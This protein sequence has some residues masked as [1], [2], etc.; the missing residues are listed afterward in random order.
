MA[1]VPAEKR[2][3]QIVE[4][5]ARVIARAGLESATTRV[6]AAEAGVPQG[7]LHYAFRDKT[8]LLAAVFQYLGER[9]AAMLAAC[10]TDGCGLEVGVRTL[11]A[12]CIEAWIRDEEMLVANYQVYFWCISPPNSTDL[13]A[14]AYVAYKAVIAEALQRAAGGALP[15]ERAAGLAQFLLNAMDGILIQ[16]LADRDATTARSSA[17]A[18]AEAALQRYG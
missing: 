15:E 7:T 17:Q 3:R 10:V 8:E 9:D 16:Y 6:I 1:Y 2:R 14:R 18:F 11:I 4:A 13:G 5:A 12:K